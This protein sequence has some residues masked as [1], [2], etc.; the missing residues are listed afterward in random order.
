MPEPYRFVGNHPDSLAS[1]RAI[2]PFDEVPAEQVNPDHPHDAALIDE[3]KL[4]PIEPAPPP[5][6]TGEAL[7]KRAA[8]LDIEGRSDMSADQKRAAIE[9]KE[10]D[11]AAQAAAEAQQAR[12]AEED[13]TT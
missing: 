4:L 10:A 8:D 9:R 1:G 7:D 3:G 5:K 11:L 2:A 6:L 12:E 13:K